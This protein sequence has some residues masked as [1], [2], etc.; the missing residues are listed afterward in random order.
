M[1]QKPFEIQKT[2]IKD[3]VYAAFQHLINSKLKF[4]AKNWIVLNVMYYV[5]GYNLQ[6]DKRTG[7]NKYQQL[8]KIT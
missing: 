4:L 3:L 8:Q 2:A 6:F 7:Q 1:V 5:L